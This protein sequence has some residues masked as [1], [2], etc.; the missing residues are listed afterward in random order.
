[1]M[2]RILGIMNEHESVDLVISNGG[3]IGR[4]FLMVACVPVILMSIAG[5]TKKAPPPPPPP[6]VQVMEVTATN[7][8]MSTEIIGQLD[9]PQNVEVRARV[10]GFVDKMLFIE[11][12][13]VKE[14]DP[15]FLL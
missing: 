8:P 2:R 12:M 3:S 10:E 9:S 15:L 11:G 14:G 1:M 13:E 7:I 5:C 6:V 4:S